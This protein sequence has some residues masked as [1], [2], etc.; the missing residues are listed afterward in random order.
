MKTDLKGANVWWMETF[1][2]PDSR[3]KWPHFCIIE[4]HLRLTLHW[5]KKNYKK[6]GQ[7]NVVVTCQVLESVK[8]IKFVHIWCE[9]CEYGEGWYTQEVTW[10]RCNQILTFNRV[11]GHT[12]VWECQRSFI[13]KAAVWIASYLHHL[14]MSYHVEK[15]SG[16]AAGDVERLRVIR[17]DQEVTHL[18]FDLPP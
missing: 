8:N 14:A 12:L 16:T 2:F 18:T 6:S 11:T 4:A 17:L 3:P 1:R 15:N 5:C 9:A 13:L 7:I 10:T